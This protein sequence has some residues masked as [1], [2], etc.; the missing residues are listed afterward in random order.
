MVKCTY[1][2]IP[3]VDES[4]ATLLSQ[5]F[6]IWGAEMGTNEHGVTIG[7]EA[8]F[9]REPYE[10]QPGLI[11]MD[12]LR[13]AL[14]RAATAKDAVSVITTL[15]E[16]YG[17]GGGCGHEDKKF[18]YHNSFIVGPEMER[19]T[20]ARGTDHFKRVDDS[21]VP[22]QTLRSGQDAFFGVPAA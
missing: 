22:E 17:Q 6:W 2:E 11:G 1:I 18:T 10:R 21:G 5:P 7:N 16:K 8:V 9:T 19:G 3:D 12:L 15:L 14:E 4:H 20:G 13:L